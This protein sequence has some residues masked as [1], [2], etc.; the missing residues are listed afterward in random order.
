MRA[1]SHYPII[2]SIA[3]L[4]KEQYEAHQCVLELDVAVEDYGTPVFGAR[5][6]N[7]DRYR[8]L[9]I[10]NLVS[11]WRKLPAHSR[12]LD[13]GDERRKLESDPYVEALFLPT[14]VR[15]CVSRNPC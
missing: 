4:G 10:E 2:Q 5:I 6:P 15:I 7:G 8:S 9:V 11:T 3:D 12:D 14:I 13:V 1:T